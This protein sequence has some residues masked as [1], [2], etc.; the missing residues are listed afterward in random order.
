MYQRI[1]LWAAPHKAQK[2]QAK[3]AV[4]LSCISCILDAQS[5]I[6]WP[7]F[8]GTEHY[9]VKAVDLG[10]HLRGVPRNPQKMTFPK[11][12]TP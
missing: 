10:A 11:G 9:R 8:R 6:L 12:E 3:L 4:D 5:E 2:S 7:L 1:Q